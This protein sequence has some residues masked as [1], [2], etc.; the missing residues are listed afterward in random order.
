MKRYLLLV[1]CIMTTVSA[2]AQN[3]RVIKGRVFDSDGQG[4]AGAVLRPIGSDTECIATGDGSFSMSVS[5]YSKEL[6]ASASGYFPQKMEIDG[7]YMI[8]RLKTDRKATQRKEAERAERIKAEN[9]A[10][11]KAAQIKAEAEREERQKAEAQAKARAEAQAKAKAQAEKARA[12]Q[13]AKEKAMAKAEEKARLAQ[14]KKARSTE[15]DSNFRNKGLVHSLELSYGFQTGKSARVLYRYA[16]YMDY[17]NLNPISAEYLI[18]YRFNNFLSLNLGI[19]FRHYCTDLHDSPMNVGDYDDLGGQPDVLLHADGL[20]SFDIP[21]RL[22]VKSYLTRGRVQPMVSAS[23]GVHLPTGK[24]LYDAGVGC[25]FRIGRRAGIYI[26]AQVYSTP[27]PEFIMPKDMNDQVEP[28]FKGYA[29]AF[30]PGIRIGFM[31]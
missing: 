4:I 29:T 9:E 27:W 22:N 12:E 5:T 26:I 11:E 17:G 6:Q 16:G 28:G 14:Q 21:I 20:Y 23:A 8:F 24:F 19:G 15:Y 7:S 13:L 25:N 2:V 31:L 30:T 18:G 3:T 10:K 1:L